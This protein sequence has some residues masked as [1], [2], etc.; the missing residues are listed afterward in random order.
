MHGNRRNSAALQNVAVIATLDFALAPWSALLR[1]VNFDR[2]RAHCSKFNV[3]SLIPHNNRPPQNFAHCMNLDASC[4]QT[5]GTLERRSIW[6]ASDSKR[7]PPLRRAS[8]FHVENLMG[9]VHATKCWHTT[10]KSGTPPCCRRTESSLRDTAMIPNGS[11][12][13]CEFASQ[14]ALLACRSRTTQVARIRRCMKSD[15]RSSVLALHGRQLM[16]RKSESC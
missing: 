13:T 7:L 8:H 3:A 16:M 15:S 6:I 1:R 14:R 10:P 11:P 4:F 12:R 9:L 2:S 5:H